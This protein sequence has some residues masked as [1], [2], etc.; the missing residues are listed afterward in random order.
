MCDSVCLTSKLPLLYAALEHPGSRGGRER[1]VVISAVADAEA[2]GL[3]IDKVGNQER[4]RYVS[5]YVNFAET[6]P[7]F[8]I[9]VKLASVMRRRTRWKE[10][11]ERC[12]AC[13]G[14]SVGRGG[15]SVCGGGEPDC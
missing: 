10:R 12:W 15:S 13:C 7:C 3:A 9:L 5:R 8:A 6:V 14:C 11:K 4:L 1:V 2:L